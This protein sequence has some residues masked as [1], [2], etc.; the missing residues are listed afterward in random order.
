MADEGLYLLD[1]T[2]RP[3]AYVNEV[4]KGS[5]ASL[6]EGSKKANGKIVHGFKVVKIAVCAFMCHL[7]GK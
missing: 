4:I 3:C 6:Q 5:W 7:Q 2:I 1:V